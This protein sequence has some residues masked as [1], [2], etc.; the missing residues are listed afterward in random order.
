MND[1]K[2]TIKQQLILTI[3]SVL[4]GVLLGGFALNRLHI[5]RLEKDVDLM[6]IQW[7]VMLQMSSPEA[8]NVF[9]E[10]VKDLNK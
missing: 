3:M 7:Q 6:K 9:L 1:I 10:M 2:T 5:N 8:K 4:V